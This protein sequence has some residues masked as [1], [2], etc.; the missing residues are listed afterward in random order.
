MSAVEAM[1]ESDSSEGTRAVDKFYGKYMG[2]VME[3]TPPAEGDHRGELRLEIPGILEETPDGTGEQAMQ[4]IAK[5]SFAPGEFIVPDVDA[6]VWVEFIAGEIDWPV[7]SGVW[8]PEEATPHTED[9]QAPTEFQKII[10][11][12]SGHVIQLDD[13]EDEEKIVIHHKS[14]SVITIDRDGNI[15][16]EHVGGAR[17]ELKD[18]TTVAITGDTLTLTGD[19]TLDGDVHVTGATDIKGDLVVGESTTTTISGNEITGG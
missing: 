17:L 3:N 15:I 5:P 8:Y 2:R 16:I 13:T 19:I 7:W 11:T 18:D 14:Q 10:R 1:F 12:T 6:R 9:D 4:V